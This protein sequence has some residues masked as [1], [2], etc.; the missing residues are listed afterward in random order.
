MM[1]RNVRKQQVRIMKISAEVKK[2]Q[3]TQS[4]MKGP[5]KSVPSSQE[6]TMIRTLTTMKKPSHFVGWISVQCQL[7]IKYLTKISTLKYVQR[8]NKT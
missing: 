3:P 5:L 4:R 1:K 2:H 8:K 7:I 6:P